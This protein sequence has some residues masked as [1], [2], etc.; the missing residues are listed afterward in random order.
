MCGIFALLVLTGKLEGPIFVDDIDLLDFYVCG[1]YEPIK[2]R[3]KLTVSIADICPTNIL[4]CLKQR[5]PDAI[6]GLFIEKSFGSQASKPATLTWIDDISKPEILRTYLHKCEEQHDTQPLMKVLLISSVL[7]LR[8]T[9]E[10]QLCRQ[11]LADCGVAMSY[12]GE[13]FD[14][15]QQAVDDLSS[16][17]LHSEPM[18]QAIAH[19][20]T[21]TPQCSDT[22]FLFQLV[23]L[24]VPLTTPNP[25]NVKECEIGEK[26]ME[27]GAD[28][29]VKEAIASL[30]KC[31]IGE[32][33][34]VVV[35]YEAGICCV[36][37][38]SIGKRS[39]LTS[40]LSNGLMFSSN[41]PLTQ[42]ACKVEPWATTLPITDL[43][44]KYMGNYRAAADSKLIE[45]PSN[46]VFCTDF[47]AE[48]RSLSYSSIDPQINNLI[49]TPHLPS[50]DD[51]DLKPLMSQ[52]EA[53]DLVS[54]LFEASIKRIIQNIYRLGAG[55]FVEE[56]HNESLADHVV[57]EG[58]NESFKFTKSKIAVLFSGG[59][60][61][62][63]IACYLAKVLPAGE[64]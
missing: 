21:F 30:F 36:A 23:S 58:M 31:L 42:E 12:N 35:Y 55:E 44:E 14:L 20:K 9:A 64:E 33:A 2:N 60:D 27:D 59:L 49:K 17:W 47:L 7:S 24:L 54:T 29:K 62:A 22:S 16:F 8:K 18:R 56:N 1:K 3:R 53:Q 10:G 50:K 15:D 25:Q 63:L 6:G 5:G 13:I 32:Y 4:E 34:V 38:D 37:K 11:P 28:L 46:T 43:E 39:L 26:K 40:R 48:P 45:L 41:L 57:E 19:L 52:K 51:G 61:S